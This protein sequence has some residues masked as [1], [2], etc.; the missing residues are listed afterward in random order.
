MPVG[1]L[2]IEIKWKDDELKFKFDRKTGMY[3]IIGILAI[4]KRQKLTFNILTGNQVYIRIK[5]PAC[6]M[7]NV[8]YS[9]H[10]AF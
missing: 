10:S 6:V 4:Y 9:K 1:K 5:R 3:V 2:K 7:G 8:F